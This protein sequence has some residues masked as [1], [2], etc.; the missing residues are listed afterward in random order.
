MLTM[1]TE[2]DDSIEQ[3]LEEIEDFSSAKERCF[4]CGKSLLSGDYTQEH[5]VPRW[6]QRRYDLWDQRIVLLNGTS[7]PYRNLTVPCCD[8]CNKYRLKPIED[9]ISQTV[10]LGKRAVE[11]LGQMTIFLWLG[12]L[13]YG[14]LYKELTLLLNRADPTVGT[15]ITPQLIEHYRTHRFFLQQVRQMVEC[16][17]FCPG[18][19]HVFS[20]QKM[21][22]PVLEWDFCDNIDTMFVGCRVG[23]TAFFASL[24]DGGAEQSMA[25]HFAD[26]ADLDLHPIQFREICAMVCYR[27]TL[28]TRTPKYF[29]IQGRPH[30]VHQQPLGGL[31]LKP[32]FEEWE[33]DVYIK[34]LAFYLGVGVEHLRLPSGDVKSWLYDGN[35][36]PRFIDFA[37]YP[38]IPRNILD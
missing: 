20:M 38:E 26:I 11:Q 22:R 14:F 5:I 36:N 24:G 10:D 1:D 30:K 16:V 19:I 28:R 18:S 29:T 13:L 9:S 7:I 35:W 21:P 17:D 27:S 33:M 37:E 4:L 32:Y 34:Y 25:P 6:A 23:R 12:K 3:L 15:I 31:W 8:E 2:D